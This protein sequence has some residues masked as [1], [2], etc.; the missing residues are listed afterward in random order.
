MKTLSLGA[1]RIDRAI[2]LEH[3]AVD[4]NWLLANATP[5]G[6]AEEL[7][8]LGNGLVQPVTGKLIMD[9]HS[10]VIRTV[11]HTVL[12]DTCIG[13]ERDRANDPLFHMLRTDYL[14][15]LARIGVHPEEVDF[16]LCTHLHVD[17]VGW[18]VR[19]QDGEWVPT[20]PNARYLIG[21]KEL[22]YW[23]DAEPRGIGS[24]VSRAAFRDSVLPIVQAGKADLIEDGHV[25]EHELDRDLRVES[26]PGH[27]LGQVGLH[28]RCGCYH[29]LLTGDTIHHPIQ[30]AKPHWHSPADV[31]PSM[32]TRT[33]R[34]LID[35]YADTD[36]LLLSAHFPTPTAGRIISHGQGARFCFAG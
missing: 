30:V 11:R 24:P 8:W 7:P 27:T 9:F 10:F 25:V 18:N 28:V 3:V 5:D 14:A 36:T 2:E 22:D 15:N 34:G 13:N 33:R 4:P 32:S 21:R 29:A 20:F 31:D 23:L 12:V 6:I 19:R 35:R 17:H 16:V 26:L 1:V